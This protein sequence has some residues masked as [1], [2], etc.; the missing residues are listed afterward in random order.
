MNKDLKLFKRREV[1]HNKKAQLMQLLLL[2]LFR[3]DLISN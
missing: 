1:E 2:D 3:S